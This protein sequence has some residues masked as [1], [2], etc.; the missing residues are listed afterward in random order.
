[1]SLPYASAT[2]GNAARGEII[3]ILQR[4]GC[5]SVGFM[6]E[7]DTHSVILAFE[8]RKRPVQMRA[9]AQGWA[10]AYLQENPWTSRRRQ[11]KSDYEDAALRQGMI[12]INSILRDWVKGQITAIETGIMTFDHV[13]L[14]HMLT[15]DGRPGIEVMREQLSLPAPE[16]H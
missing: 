5:T 1:M 11:S 4:F 14:P 3:K 6:D 16:E 10:S 9:S 13:F 15:H 2:S 8:W 12:A 7:F